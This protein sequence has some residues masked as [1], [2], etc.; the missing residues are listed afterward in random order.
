MRLRVLRLDLL[1]PLIHGNKWFK[2]KINLDHII[3]TGAR[4]VLSF[5][6]AY[7]NHIYALAAAA[8][9]LEL[10]SIGMIRG[11]LP[12]PL[13]PVLQFAEEQ[14]ME[15]Y[16]MDRDSYRRKHEKAVLDALC[17]RFGG[18]HV[19]PEGGSNELA[20]RGCADIVQHLRFESQSTRRV[21]ALACATG[22]TMAGLL[23]GLAHQK[24]PVQEVLGISVLKA[25]G[26]PRSEIVRWLRDCPQAAKQSW[27][28]LEHYHGGGFAR[29][30]P[31]LEAFLSQFRQ[32]CD[33][34]VEPVY[35]GKLFHGL[36]DA[37][38]QGRIGADSEIIALHSGGV[39]PASL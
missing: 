21:V 12:R 16:P 39:V 14:G 34:P 17:H 22:A 11:E 15:L 1:H 10:R 35:S 9:Q 8:R 20:V 26:Y 5:G 38:V 6:G 2:L 7:S 36:V 18:V 31:E 25:R 3:A 28:V 23:R 13:N 29:S 32:Y 4:T 30:S 19:L 27:D 37:V 24:I 33:I